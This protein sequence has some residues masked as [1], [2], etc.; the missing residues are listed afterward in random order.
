M[1]QPVVRERPVYGPDSRHSFFWDLCLSSVR[2]DHAASE[3]LAKHEAHDAPERARRAAGAV[4]AF[5]T[6]AAANDLETR[7]NPNTTLGTG[8]EFSPPLWLMD[9]F[10]SGARA[11]RPFGDLLQPIPLPPG[12]H[13]INTP[14][15][16]TGSLAGPQTQD[17]EVLTSQD[18]VT[19]QI[20]AP[21]VTIGGMLDVSQQLE[22]QAPAGFDTYA[23]VDLH[24]AYNRAL[25][26]Q[27]LFG[28]GVGSQ[29]L[30]VANVTGINTVDGTSMTTI[31]T[32]WPGLGQT[33]AAVGNNRFYPPEI[34]LMAPRRWF[35]IASSVDNSSRPIASPGNTGP[36][37]A[38]DAPYVG[39]AYSVGPVLGIPTFM[40]GVIPAGTNNDTVFALRPSDM[41]L[42]ES[43]PKTLVTPESL[44]GTLQVRIRMFHYV[45]F[46]SNRYPTGIGVLKNLTQPSNF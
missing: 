27:L 45:A 21:V 15:M 36:A 44:S 3:R 17:G 28:T 19:T 20:S 22:D 10:A 18:L 11:G 32:F 2:G 16:T 38:L 31:A 34:W 5:E 14:R 42:W 7:V 23:Y 8:G 9:R 37:T 43:A 35:W 39:G 40:D 26:G 24:R 13:S 33:A 1:T 46:M 25:E 30:G 41:F 4:A 6:H 29:M 12:V